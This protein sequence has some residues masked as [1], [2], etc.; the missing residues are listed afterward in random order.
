MDPN[1]TLNDLLDALARND[2]AK[3]A[4]FARRLDWHLENGY[5]LPDMDNFGVRHRVLGYLV[6]FVTRE[7]ARCSDAKRASLREARNGDAH[8][9]RPFP[10]R[11]ARRAL[12]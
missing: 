9:K 1:A 6:S 11:E 8:G 2:V 4:K 10:L 12:R 7:A 3:A 5:S